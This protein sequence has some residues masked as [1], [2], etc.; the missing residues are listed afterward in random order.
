MLKT[1]KEVFYKNLKEK[2]DSSHVLIMTEYKGL[3]VGELTELR[4][5]LRNV[6][7]EY[8]VVKNTLLSLALDDMYREQMRE[9]LAGPTA[10]ALSGDDPVATIKV[11]KKFSEKFQNLKIKAGIYDGKILSAQEL[12]DIAS[13]PSIEVL[14]TMLISRLQSPLVQLINVFQSPVRSLIGALN[15]ISKKKQ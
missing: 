4:R 8:R 15:E 11:L 7:V 5:E 3:K 12:K 1:E 9:Y 2:I 13:L 6:A 10:V 14:Y